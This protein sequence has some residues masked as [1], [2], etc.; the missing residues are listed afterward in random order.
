MNQVPV[1]KVDKLGIDVNLIYELIPLLR[2]R[3]AYI[4]ER[5]I[6]LGI[7]GKQLEKSTDAGKDK[8]PSFS[9]T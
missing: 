5:S 3:D 2:N 4:M 7:Q 8:K 6:E 1:E 9:W